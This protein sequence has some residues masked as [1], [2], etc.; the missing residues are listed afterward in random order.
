[1]IDVDA[2]ALLQDITRLPERM[3]VRFLRESQTTA[4]QLEREMRA[5]LARQLSP[6]ATGASVES[7]KHRLAYDGNGYVVLTERNPYPNL[8]LWLEKGTKPGKRKNFARTQPRPF[9]YASIL[10]EAPGHQRRIR[11]AWNDLSSEINR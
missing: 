8:P 11:D 9:F 5:R 4:E 6:A 2:A 7:I 3:R 1:M 10:L